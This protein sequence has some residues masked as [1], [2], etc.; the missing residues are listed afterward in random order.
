MEVMGY[1]ADDEVYKD[2]LKFHVHPQ[3]RVGVVW[4]PRWKWIS[5]RRSETNFKATVKALAFAETYMAVEALVALTYDW[6]VQREE[7]WPLVH[8]DEAKIAAA[9]EVDEG[10][11]RGSKSST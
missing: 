1:R 5:G 9:Q 11:S 2:I 8:V 4:V 6:G 10:K 3:T 7:G